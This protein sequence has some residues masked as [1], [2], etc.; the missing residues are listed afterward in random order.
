M[1][2]GIQARRGEA[3]FVRSNAEVLIRKQATT[4]LGVGDRHVGVSLGFPIFGSV[5][6][7]TREQGVVST[8]QPCLCRNSKTETG[9]G[10]LREVLVRTARPLVPDR[11]LTG[12][13]AAVNDVADD[14]SGRGWPA[15]LSM[16]AEYCTLSGASVLNA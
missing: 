1:S 12:A 14:L 15:L 13:Q 16:G 10:Y 6:R 3:A 9:W 5:G 4:R 11:G 7:L 2:V 8:G